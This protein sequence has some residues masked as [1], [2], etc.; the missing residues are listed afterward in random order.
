MDDSHRNYPRVCT[1]NEIP[2]IAPYYVA[3]SK[4]GSIQGVVSGKV[5]HKN[6]GHRDGGLGM[7]RGV[8]SANNPK[9]GARR[10]N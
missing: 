10:T 6:V 7:A 8:E 2:C 1:N 3:T 4:E 9:D 5:L